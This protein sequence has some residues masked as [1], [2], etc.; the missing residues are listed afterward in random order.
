MPVPMSDRIRLVVDNIIRRE[1]GYTNHPND[2]GGPT[3]YGI[4][5]AD[6]SEVRGAP[7]T[8]ANVKALTRDEASM[9][10]LNRYIV[11]PGFDRLDSPLFELVVDTAVNNGRGRAILWLQRACGAVEDGILGPKTVRAAADG[12]QH[13]YD[14]LLKLRLKAYGALVSQNSSLSVF[15][16]GWINRVCEFMP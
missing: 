6:L 13:T 5:L 3:N 9:I 12:G 7:Q 14:A 10:Y 4:T 11:G 15:I 8:A 1:G 2:P 16:A